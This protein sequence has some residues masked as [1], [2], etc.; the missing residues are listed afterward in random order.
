MTIII[1]LYLLVG[2]YFRKVA[3]SIEYRG[4]NTNRYYTDI[5]EYSDSEAGEK[6][7][8]VGEMSQEQYDAGVSVVSFDEYKEYCQ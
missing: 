5:L 2:E 8:R 4:Y 3:E 7:T 6:W 1:N